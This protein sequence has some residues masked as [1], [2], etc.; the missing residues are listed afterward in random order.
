[1]LKLF[2]L[3]LG[4]EVSQLISKGLC[5]ILGFFQKQSDKFLFSTVR[6]KKNEFV[7]SFFWKH[8]RIPN[9]V[10]KLSDL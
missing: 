1:M 2:S 4:F 5:G 6:Q 10:S 3:F 9:V 8:L 7:R